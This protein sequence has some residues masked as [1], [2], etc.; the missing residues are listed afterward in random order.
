MQQLNY[1]SV[2][3]RVRLSTTRIIFK[4][5]LSCLL[6]LSSHCFIASSDEYLSVSTFTLSTNDTQP[7]G[8]VHSSAAW[9]LNQIVVKTSGG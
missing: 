4:S 3:G 9:D 6:L 7:V 1:S 8:T 5:V 2:F